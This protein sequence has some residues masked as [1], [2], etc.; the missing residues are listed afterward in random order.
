MR[1]ILIEIGGCD[2]ITFLVLG[3]MIVGGV[4]WIKRWFSHWEEE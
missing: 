4:Y 3:C 1:E 2:I